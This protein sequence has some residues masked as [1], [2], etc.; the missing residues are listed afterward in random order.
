MSWQHSGGVAV[1]L[2]NEPY[3]GRQTECQ[4]FLSEAHQAM[5]AVGEWRIV[6]RVTG[7]IR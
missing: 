6:L 3:E 5:M 4:E 7:P 2:P 1:V